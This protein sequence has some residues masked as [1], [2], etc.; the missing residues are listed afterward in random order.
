MAGL[1][2][3]I[4]RM[5]LEMQLESLTRQRAAVL[6][7]PV[8]HKLTLMWPDNEDPRWLYYEVKKRGPRVRYAYSTNRNLAGYFLGWRETVD[9]KGNGKRDQF[10][11]SKR[12]KTVAD[13]TL[14]RFKA[15]K[16]RVKQQ[17]KKPLEER[18]TTYW[19]SER[20]PGPQPNATGSRGL[21]KVVVEGG[22]NNALDVARTKWPNAGE[23]VATHIGRR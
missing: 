15:H 1:P 23:L 10:I 18:R 14:A 4:Q 22:P 3:P 6:A 5:M 8:K 11:A 9:R 20:I 19:I 21:G 16:E 12:R 7:D 13:R 2:E 17:P